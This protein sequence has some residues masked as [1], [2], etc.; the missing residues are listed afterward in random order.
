MTITDHLAKLQDLTF[1]SRT[2]VLFSGSADGEV[3][4][5]K[6]SKLETSLKWMKTFQQHRKA[7]RKLACDQQTSLYVSCGE[8]YNVI[9]YGEDVKYCQTLLKNIVNSLIVIGD[10]KCVCYCMDGSFVVIDMIK[11]N[12]LSQ[13][14]LLAGLFVYSYVP[15]TKLFVSLHGNCI[16][17]HT[18]DKVLQKVPAH[19]QPF[20]YLDYNPYTKTIVTAGNDCCLGVWQHDP[21]KNNIKLK[22]FLSGESLMHSI[23]QS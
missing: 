8:D 7:V 20:N 3:K 12:V 23:V 6:L 18:Q 5:W 15:E 13:H 14:K 9:I 16:V 11:G 17:L 4:V 22:R 10:N 21:N 1:N 19:C 2:K